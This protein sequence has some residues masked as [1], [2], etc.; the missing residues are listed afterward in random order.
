MCQTCKTYLQRTFG[1]LFGLYELVGQVPMAPVAPMGPV[2]T[3]AAEDA[4]CADCGDSDDLDY[5]NKDGECICESCSD[6][7]FTCTDCGEVGDLDDCKEHDGRRYRGEKWCESCF[8]D[9][10]TQCECC[11]NYFVTDDIV[12]QDGSDYCNEC[13]SEHYDC[14]EGCN[15]W[16]SRDNMNYHER[17]GCCYCDDCMPSS[18]GECEACE[19]RFRDDDTFAKIGS[20][21]TFGVEL[22]TSQ[23]DDI[24]D[25]DGQTH[26]TA[27]EDGSISGKEFVS[28]V[29]RGDRGLTAISDFCDN[30]SSFDVDSRC[31]F[32]LHIGAA[33]LSDEAKRAVC[34]AYAMSAKVWGSFVHRDRRENRFC[35]QFDWSADDMQTM[36]DSEWEGWAAS[37]PRYRWVNF[38]AYAVHN[39]FE[40]RLHTATLD[41]GKVCNWVVAHVKFVDYFS[42]LTCDE[43]CALWRLDDRAWFAKLAEIWGDDELTEFYR[44][45]A[46]KFG[47][48]YSICEEVA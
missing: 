35:K 20:L 42:K 13:H 9:K 4:V 1:E 48:N 31:G 14:C 19:F 26:F 37:Q 46:C 11:N 17:H 23:C 10:F 21:R 40:V 41:G 18:D 38:A 6:D 27:C 47:T 33:D 15:D 16:V 2:V 5:L 44:Q 36:E 7:Y 8:D 45:R 25:L 32:H 3:E 24:A 12:R 29:L 34:A 22:E 43:V 30:A 39:T 28:E